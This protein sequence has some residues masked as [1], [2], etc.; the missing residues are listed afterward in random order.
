[1]KKRNN[2]NKQEAE[3]IMGKKDTFFFKT[4]KTEFVFF[5]YMYLGFF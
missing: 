4:Q 2:G 1:M 3:Q 5:T